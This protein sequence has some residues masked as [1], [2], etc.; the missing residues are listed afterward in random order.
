MGTMSG[1]REL[2]EESM[3]PPMQESSSTSTRITQIRSTSC[4]AGTK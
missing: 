1:S 2:K 3:N 4:P